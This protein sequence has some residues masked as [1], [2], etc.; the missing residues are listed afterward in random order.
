MTIEMLEPTV[1]QLLTNFSLDYTYIPGSTKDKTEDGKSDWR[2]KYIVHIFYKQKLVLSTEYSMGA[3]HIP[4]WDNFGWQG[5]KTVHDL[6]ILETILKTGT[7]HVVMGPKGPQLSMQPLPIAPILK[8]VMYCLISDSDAAQYRDFEDWAENYGYDADS[9]KAEKI[10]Q[11]CM[12]IALKLRA[13]LGD[14]L[15]AEL[16]VAFQDY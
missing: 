12:E 2:L 10:Y 1:D 13:E 6:Q 15:M 4:G 7:H 14:D 3:A 9:R 5:P 8:D 11:A 16:R